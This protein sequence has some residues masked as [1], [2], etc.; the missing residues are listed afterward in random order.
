MLPILTAHS[1]DPPLATR[2]TAG[3]TTDQHRLVWARRLTG[4]TPANATAEGGGPPGQHQSGMHSLLGIV[5]G[6]TGSQAGPDQ[7]TANRGGLPDQ[8]QSRSVS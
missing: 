5:L 1:T 4:R 8:H 3:G 6:S 7:C 2:Q